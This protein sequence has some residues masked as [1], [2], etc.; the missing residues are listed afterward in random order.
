MK[1]ARH[2]RKFYR[3]ELTTDPPVAASAWEASFDDGATWD[4]ATVI[5]GTSAWLVAGPD[6]DPGTAVAVL[7]ESVTPLLRAIDSPEILDGEGEAPKIY[8]Q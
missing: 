5:D 8:L 1:L 2:A 7:T 4:Q 3:L 6:A